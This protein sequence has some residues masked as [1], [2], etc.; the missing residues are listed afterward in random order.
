MSTAPI[1]RSATRGP[2]LSE[3]R[4]RAETLLVIVLSLACL[5]LAFA[6]LILLATYSA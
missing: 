5:A 6:D 4:A 2:A 1:T 3:R